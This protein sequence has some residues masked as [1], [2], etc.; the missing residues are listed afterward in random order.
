MN[1]FYAIIAS[2]FVSLISLIGILSIIIERKVFEKFLFIFISFAAGSLIGISFLHII[3]EVSESIGNKISFYL[4]VLGFTC[5][6]ILEKY[7]FWRH[8]HRGDK[9][10]YHPV[11]YLNLIGDGIHN[12]IDGLFIGSAF[13]LNINAGIISTIAVIIHEVPQEIGDFSILIH[14]GMNIKRA[15]KVNFL[16]SLTAVVGCIVGYFSSEVVRSLP[17]YLLP[18]VAGGFIYIASCDLI[19]GLHREKNIKNSLVSF[20]FFIL[21]IFIVMF[22]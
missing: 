17:D 10:E 22:L 5:F 11:S 2:S 9:C 6:F 21:G 7:F 4:V 20:G 1:L 15:L 12:F 16:I 13:C 8:C 19:P 14:G 18:I 3:P